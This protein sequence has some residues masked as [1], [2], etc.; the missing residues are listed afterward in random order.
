MKSKSLVK[1]E[2]R[3]KGTYIYVCISYQFS[4]VYLVSLAADSP[5]I[6]GGDEQ[7]TAVEGSAVSLPCIAIGGSEASVTWSRDGDED[8]LL[9]RNVV[10]SDNSLTIVEV[11]P[12]SAGTYYC[13]AANDYGSHVKTVTLN[14]DGGRTGRRR[15]RHCK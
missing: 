5:F 14:D 15:R 13:T 11:T 9:G 8:I 10:T 3:R 2:I 7:L 4:I 1:L 12:E 6:L